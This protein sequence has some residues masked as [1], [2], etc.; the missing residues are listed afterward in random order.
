MA[1]CGV[2]LA[3]LFLATPR[4][5]AAQDT[6]APFLE[7]LS[8][9]RDEGITRGIRPEIVEQALGS[10]AEP[11]AY[12]L[13]RD[14]AQ[15]E[16]VLTLESYI[17]RRVNE[18][19]IRNGRLMLQRHRALLDRV[20]DRYG[21]PAPVVVAIWGME[22]NY[23]R[24]TGAQPIIHVL[25]TL[26]WNPR[27]ADFFRQ[28]LFSALDILNR[29]YI[30]LPRMRGSWAGAMGQPQFMP[31]SYLEYAVDFNGD[32]RRDIWET[33]GDI[34]ASI[35]HYLNEHGWVEGRRWGREVAVPRGRD[36]DIAT[37]SEGCRARRQMTVPLR[38]EEWQGLGVRL[39]GGGALPQ[40]DFPAS[41][42]S[43][44]RRHFLVYDNYDA[45]LSYNCA[46]PYALSVGLLSDRIA[47]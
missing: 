3:A 16:S 7:W 27:R 45:L 17:A 1:A 5:P 13:E 23:G 39:P 24:V 41:L 26:A 38:L 4:S 33:P 8:G 25:A 11:L 46:H 20:S 28:E 14:S 19:S 2:L 47:R 15:P 10:L 37:R 6:P 34:F 42:A 35:A 40:A 22:S 9:V 32:G 44:T 12:A 43:G 29:D 30:D 31:S 36:L 18:T 21:V